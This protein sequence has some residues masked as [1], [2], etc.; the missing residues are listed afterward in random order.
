[1]SFD[2]PHSFS[3]IYSLVVVGTL[4]ELEARHQMDL[5][6]ALASPVLSNA[7]E[8]AA[9]AS[10]TSCNA[11]PAVHHLLARLR[12]AVYLLLGFIWGG[13]WRVCD[14]CTRSTAGFQIHPS[15]W[16]SKGRA[17]KVFIRPQ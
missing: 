14:S 4:M 7:R 6:I 11:E 10:R 12:D 1:M 17:A 3:I 8:F 15:P 16:W 13:S 9:V 2:L 5:A